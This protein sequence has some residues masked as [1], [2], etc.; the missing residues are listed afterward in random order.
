MKNLLPLISMLLITA[1]TNYYKYPAFAKNGNAFMIVVNPAGTNTV[2]GYDPV[3]NRFDFKSDEEDS[4]EIKYLPYPV[5]FGFIPSTIQ[6]ETLA[7]TG[8][9]L[10]VLAIGST[11]KQGSLLEFVPV[12]VLKVSYDGEEDNKIVGVVVNSEI[13]TVDCKTLACLHQDYPGLVDIIETWYRNH[14][15]DADIKVLGWED[16]E[17]AL[18]TIKKWTNGN[19]DSRK[20]KFAAQ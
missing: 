8:Y 20:G 1:C 6:E 11:I 9:P 4:Y 17:L 14:R 12:G 19:S 7:G 16:E 15:N 5:N 10:D 2:Y 3:K 18:E 13:S